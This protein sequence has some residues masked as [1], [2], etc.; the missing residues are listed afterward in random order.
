MLRLPQLISELRRRPCRSIATIISYVAEN[1]EQQTFCAIRSA[2][3]SADVER[4]VREGIYPSFL[5]S[6]ITKLLTN[7]Y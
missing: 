2:M 7:S 5:A 1:F 3:D 6:Q 4:A